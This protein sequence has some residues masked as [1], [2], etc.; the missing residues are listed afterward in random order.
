MYVFRRGFN[1]ETGKVRGIEQL[2]S[3]THV[4]GNQYKILMGNPAIPNDE[5]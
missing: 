4:D 5:V 2:K 3:I 1:H